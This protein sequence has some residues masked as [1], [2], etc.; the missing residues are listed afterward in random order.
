M[1]VKL[2]IDCDL[3]VVISITS[4]IFCVFTVVCYIAIYLSLFL[5][6]KFLTLCTWESTEISKLDIL[7]NSGCKV[8]E[9]TNE[10]NFIKRA[11]IHKTTTENL[12][13]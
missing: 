4:N 11:I 5:S 2:Y 10:T 12:V 6:D 7:V 3:G 1:R 8:S 13:S 9:N